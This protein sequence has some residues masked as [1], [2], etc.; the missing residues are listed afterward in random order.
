MPEYLISQKDPRGERAEQLAA[1]RAAHTYDMAYGFPVASRARAGQ[2]LHPPRS[3]QPLH[4]ALDGN[5][6]VTH[7]PIFAHSS[8]HGVSRIGNDGSRSMTQ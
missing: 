1:L 6:C 7:A 5:G 2:L 4:D 8:S 3:P